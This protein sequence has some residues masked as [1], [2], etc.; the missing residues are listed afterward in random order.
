[1]QLW[2]R[3]FLTAAGSLFLLC[4]VTVQAAEVEVLRGEE[5]ETEVYLEGTEDIYSFFG[6]L[7]A[8]TGYV[9]LRD[10]KEENP[11]FYQ[12]A[13]CET[14]GSSTK[15][16][17]S[18][19]GS[20][21]Y[22]LSLRLRVEGKR[23]GQSV[24][25]FSGYQLTDDAG[26]W[27][28]SATLP[29][30]TVKVLPNPL[31]IELS[32]DMG[33]DGWFVS[34]VRVT[35]SDKDAASIWYDTGNGTKEYTNPFLLK[36]GVYSIL[37]TSDDGYGYKKQ[38]KRTCS[39]DTTRPHLTASETGLSWQ[40]EDIVL[41]VSAWDS[42][43]GMD[44][45]A[46]ACSEDKEAFGGLEVFSG[47]ETLT[48]TQDG[49]WYLYLTGEDV[50][51]NEGER[52]LGP[53]RKDSVAPEVL[54]ENIMEGQLVEKVV[55]PEIYSSDDRSGIKSITYFLDGEK[56]TLGEI[57]G[58]GYHTLSVTVED[59]A[60][61]TATDRVSFVIYDPV[62]IE[63]RAEDTRYTGEG[64][65]SATV[66]YNGTPLAGR[67]A[68]FFLNGE[69]VGVR[70]TDRH[71]RVFLQMPVEIAPQEAVLTVKTGQED[72]NFL[73]AGEGS[74][75]FTVEQENAWL[76]AGV[77]P[78]TEYGDG[79]SVYLETG[80]IPDFRM[81]DITKAELSVTLYVTEKDGSRTFLEE[82]WVHPEEDGRVCCDF[83]PEPGLYEIMIA[84]T[85]NSYYTGQKQK[86]H[87][88][89]YEI[90]ASLTTEGGS[91]LLDLP[92]FGIY[93]KADL[94]FSP[95]FDLEVTTELRIPGT[96]ITL[97]E[98]RLT[99]YD[100]TTEGLVLY[101]TAVNPKDRTTY[102]YEVRIAYSPGGVVTEAE[103]TL[104]KGNNTTG[105]PAYHYEWPESEEDSEGTEEEPESGSE[106]N[107]EE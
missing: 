33:N 60:G 75:T 41:T 39:I 30:I 56:W 65:F 100:L 78:V 83:Y 88:A 5:A 12:A 96:G 11:L 34:P 76:H 58:K 54:I 98:N 20:G 84:F 69:S 103:I 40:K 31:N 42:G 21:S 17:L 28:E 48:L 81:G 53:Y 104:W 105:E 59:M 77:T 99:D 89:V 25:T 79:L 18:S 13:L 62:E 49:V 82:V 2:K 36:D 15:L 55:L 85:E 35:V 26:A 19:Y 50:A 9:Y 102:S 14:D 86:A 46:R 44:F 92:Q 80:E 43:S 45:S 71:G 8:D 95:E 107:T 106:I 93:V 61:N 72:E 24:L 10:V 37:V 27:I 23:I 94:V 91:L 87:A 63:V 7:E 67:E 97:T 52:V 101:G 47:S 64:F 38:E 6:T 68:G 32:G 22:G 16:L 73:L 4:P 1:M 90:Q 51:G 66:T 57:R 3:W 74:T 29:E 70:T